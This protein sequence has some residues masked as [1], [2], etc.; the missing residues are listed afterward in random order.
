MILFMDI[1]SHF[2]FRSAYMFLS[3]QTQLSS[4]GLRCL[5]DL[6]LSGLAQLTTP[7]K[8]SLMWVTEAR[9]ILH[10][11]FVYTIYRGIARIKRL[12]LVNMYISKIHRDNF[13]MI[14]HIHTCNTFVYIYHFTCLIMYN[15]LTIQ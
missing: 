10:L 8:E 6:V 11:N 3:S 13:N 1:E 2:H 5:C 14:S 15:C 7:A 4:V 12:R 9:D